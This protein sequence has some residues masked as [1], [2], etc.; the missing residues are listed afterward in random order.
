LGHKVALADVSGGGPVIRFGMVIGSATTAVPQGAWVHT[1]NL[2][3]NY[4]ETYAHRG[5]QT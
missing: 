5:G 2:A 4:I 1:H 3:S